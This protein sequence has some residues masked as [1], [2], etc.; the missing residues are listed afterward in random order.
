MTS[1]PADSAAEP[2]ET[3]A[4]APACTLLRNLADELKDE[5]Q[6][7]EQRAIQRFQAQSPVRTASGAAWQPAYAETAAYAHG[8]CRGRSAGGAQSGAARVDAMLENLL[9]RLVIAPL[10]QPLM[11]AIS[12]AIPRDS[13]PRLEAQ[14]RAVVR[15]EPSCV[16][17][18]VGRCEGAS[19]G[20]CAGRHRVGAT[21]RAADARR[22]RRRRLTD[23][24][25]LPR[26][27]CDACSRSSCRRGV[28]WRQWGRCNG[29]ATV[30]FRS[31]S[32]TFSCW[33]PS[34]STM[35]PRNRAT[36]CLVETAC[37]R[38]RR[39]RRPAARP[40][41]P[42]AGCVTRRLSADLLLCAC[43]E[44]P[45]RGGGRGAVHV[46]RWRAAVRPCVTA[47]ARP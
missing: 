42:N 44:R 40:R 25:G 30:A 11:R 4:T 15:Y 39:S 16:D 47:A 21:H 17:V 24:R 5:L 43:P 9:Q 28:G 38:G 7:R 33:R 12:S 29:S 41:A 35:T 23:H 20:R 18:K 2:A 32:L 31:R 34:T 36:M 6:Q 46:R 45:W 13:V 10:H 14:M 22:R 3:V 37:C 19:Q 8:R 26:S 27:W 1:D